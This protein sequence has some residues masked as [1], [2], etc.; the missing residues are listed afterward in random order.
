MID[1]EA[2]SSPLVN[3]NVIAHLLE[4]VLVAVHDPDSQNEL[5][6][7][8]VIENTVQVISKTLHNNNKTCHGG[9]GSHCFC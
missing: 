7:V 8:V 1:M 2:V 6:S 4:L 5:L 3:K 9:G